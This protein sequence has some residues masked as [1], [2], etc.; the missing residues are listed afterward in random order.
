MIPH[1]VCQQHGVQHKEETV[2]FVGG[3]QNGNGLSFGAGRC[4]VFYADETLDRFRS[5]VDLFVIRLN[6]WILSDVN[7]LDLAPWSQ[8]ERGTLGALK[9]FDTS[10]AVE[11]DIVVLD[12]LKVPIR[13]KW[14]VQIEL[15]LKALVGK[16]KVGRNRNHLRIHVIQS[17]NAVLKTAKFCFANACEGGWEEH[18]DDLLAAEVRELDRIHVGV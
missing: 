17:C 14:E 7:V 3:L 2:A 15:L 5:L 12:R 1:C 10:E 11:D 6:A 9:T 13:E 16:W 4:S 18:Q 8:N